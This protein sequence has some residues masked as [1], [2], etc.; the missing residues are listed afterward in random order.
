MQ[1]ARWFRDRRRALR[2]ADPARRTTGSAQWRLPVSS[3]SSDGEP[4]RRRCGVGVAAAIHRLDLERVL[5]LLEVLVGE[6]GTTARPPATIELA[7]EGEP[8]GP[9]PAEEPDRRLV[10]VPVDMEAS[11]GRVRRVALLR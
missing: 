5:A 8:P 4:P 7:P 6:R 11:D 3:E 9:A 2:R 1:S 10:R